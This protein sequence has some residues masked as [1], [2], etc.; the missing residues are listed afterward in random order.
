METGN[1][2]SSEKGKLTPS[3]QIMLQNIQ[4]ISC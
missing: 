4:I 2:G 3:L 1:T